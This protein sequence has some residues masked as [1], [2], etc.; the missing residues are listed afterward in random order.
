MK[1]Y[2][3]LVCFIGTHSFSQI[4]LEH[5]DFVSV[6]DTIVEYYERFPTSTIDVGEPGPNKVWDFS[7]LKSTA[8]DTLVFVDPQDTP[9]GEDF[10][11]SN[12][13]LYSNNGYYEA[14]MFMNHSSSKLVGNGSGVYVNKKKRV[15][16]RQE[17]VIKYPLNYQ[18][19]SSNTTEEDKIVEKTKKGADSIKRTRVF[20]HQTVVDSWGDIILPKGTFLSLRLKHVISVTDFFYKKEL[21]Q[22]VLLNQ[23]KKN[24]GIFYQWWTQDKKVKHPVAQISMDE[25]HKKPIIA[26][27]L[28]AKPFLEIMKSV[29]LQTLKI[30]PNPAIRSTIIDVGVEVSYI[31][32]YS[33]NGQL[34]KNIKTNISK[35]EIN[36]EDFASATYFVVVRDEEGKIIGKGQLIKK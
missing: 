30:Y 14:W 21:D 1:K 18:D 3:M 20:E 25:H 34:I 9:F 32:I 31:S 17:T 10:T 26:K 24:T 12:I 11:N 5:N 4:T 23:S 13:A 22:W 6:G 36:V 2:L 35:T 15:D 7:N 27:F 28:P 19:T 29:P 16:I 8:R 33:F